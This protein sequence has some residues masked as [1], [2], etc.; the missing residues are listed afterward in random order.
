M[1]P[2]NYSINYYRFLNILIFIILM[3]KSTI[4]YQISENDNKNK[5]ENIFKE[6][7]INYQLQENNF[8]IY[9][10][11]VVIAQPVIKKTINT[12]LDGIEQMVDNISIVENDDYLDNSSI[13]E[14]DDYQDNSYRV[15]SLCSMCII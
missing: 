11:D 15:C 13:V 2:Q 7:Q 8:V 5:L 3:E 1:I 10:P 6:L 12:R 9:I 14:K 4:I